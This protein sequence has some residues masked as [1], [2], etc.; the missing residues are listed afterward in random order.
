M[1]ETVFIS[2]EW[3]FNTKGGVSMDIE[4]MLY[5]KKS[6]IRTALGEEEADLILRGCKLVNLFT[7][8]VETVNIYIKDRYIASITPD[9]LRGNN[10]IECSGY[11]ALPGFIDGHIHVDSTLLTLSQLANVILP[12][13][14]TTLMVDPMEIGNVCGIKGVKEFL[15]EA[16]ELPLK[17][18]IQICSQVPTAPGLETTGAVIGVE[19]IK[20]MLEIDSV[21]ALGELDIFKLIPLKNEYL[22]KLLYAES[23]NKI[24]VGHAAGLSGKVLE[25]YAAGGL[26]D[27]H[28]CVTKEEAMERL[29]LGMEI[30]IREGS[31]ERNL[32]ELI[33]MVT[34]EELDS[35]FLFF[36]TD[37]KHFNDIIHEGHID[38][39][40]RK[41][42]FL[43]VKPTDA[44]KMGSFNCARHF[45]VDHKVG[46]ISPSRIADIVLTKNLKDI[47]AEMVIADGKM[48]ARNGMMVVDLPVY[49]WPAWALDTVHI[50]S[51]IEPKKLQLYATG[52]KAQ[53]RVIEVIKDQIIN[54]ASEAE[55]PILNGKVLPD[56]NQDVLKF[57]CVE[58]HRASGEVGISFVRGF[59]LKSGA[60]A[61]SVAHDHHNIVAIGTND[62]DLIMAVNTVQ[63]LHGGLAVTEAGKILGELPLEIGGL[64]SP[65]PIDKMNEAITN[66][67]RQVEK[68]GCDIPSPFMILSFISLPTVPEY[69]LTN[70]G[71]VDVRN[72]KLINTLVNQ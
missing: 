19:E 5:I 37:D 25:A 54:K 9:T 67:N 46:S 68:L 57:I 41:A 43:G 35:R 36:C 8:Q 28:E 47:R 65:W 42:I 40:I 14:T 55:L 16:E 6:L 2:S 58:R 22:L 44:V 66:L 50:G 32:E 15:K 4:K 61:G 31:S 34:E 71:L 20:E 56:I 69:G 49:Q 12:C 13:G 27:D 18:F 70:K 45:R 51:S 59:G 1:V 10:I 39:N 24:R 60:I 26:N 62:E 33:K 53:V 17:V 38:Y 30:M 48:V 64:M 7:D 11:Y 52:S 21:I 29:R 63:K 23:K 72:H 3:C